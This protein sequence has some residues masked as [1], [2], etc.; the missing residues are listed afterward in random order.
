[1]ASFKSYATP[2]SFNP[3]KVPDEAQKIKDDA[4]EKIKLM[5]RDLKLLQ[6]NQQ[7]E[8]NLRQE[9]RQLEDS[10]RQSSFQ[11]DSEMRG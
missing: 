10:S 6:E 2:G 1:M 8:S 9:G 11:F 4:N 7:V 5:E 3:F